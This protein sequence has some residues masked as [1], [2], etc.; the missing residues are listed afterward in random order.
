[1]VKQIQAIRRQEPTNCLSVLDR[2]VGFAHKGLRFAHKNHVVKVVKLT[3]FSP[4]LF[5]VSGR[6]RTYM[7]Q[8]SATAINRNI[9]QV[10]IFSTECS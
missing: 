4:L 10:L 8:T 7:E 1:M 6:R 2:F 3:V 9:Y 5:T